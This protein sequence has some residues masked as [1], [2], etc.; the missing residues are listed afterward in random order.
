MNHKHRFPFQTSIILL[1]LPFIGALLFSGCKAAGFKTPNDTGRS[2]ATVY[3]RDGTSQKGILTV[4]FENPDPN[5]NHIYF[6]PDHSTTFKT[7]DY[8]TIKSYSIGAD[9]YVPK[10]V[11]IYVNDTKLY[12]FVKRLTAENAKL[13]LFEL[14][15][16]YK[17]SSSG[18][19]NY[20]YFISTLGGG[21]YDAV[22][23]NSSRLL[24]LENGMAVYVSDC[25]SLL[26]KIRDKQKGYYYSSVTFKTKRIEVIK[27]IVSEY[28]NCL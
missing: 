22:N 11:D 25:P 13:Q 18:E 19:E 21:V 4:V 17:S 16:L 9:V 5:M 6:I 10:L 20:E 12:L 28:N 24:P 23:I 1:S 7:L 14:H 15:Q 27:R 8:K 3:F 2:E 26:Q